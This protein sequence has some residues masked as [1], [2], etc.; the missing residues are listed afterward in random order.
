MKPGNRGDETPDRSAAVPKFGDWDEKNP[1]SA[2]GYT[3]IFNQVRE[4]R[5]MEAGKSPAVGNERSYTAARKQNTDDD[6][7]S[8]C[9]PWGRK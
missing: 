4:Q 5:L 8:C 1:E 7:K 3:H 9:F 2:D 6:I